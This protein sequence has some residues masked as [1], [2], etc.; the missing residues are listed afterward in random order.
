M[1]RD[2]ALLIGKES[3]APLANSRPVQLVYRKTVPLLGG[4]YTWVGTRELLSY[5]R[6]LLHNAA[7]IVKNVTL[8]ADIDEG[9]FTSSI[10]AIPE[11]MLYLEGTGISPEFRE[12]LLM[13]KYLDAYWYRLLIEPHQNPDRIY[14]SFQGVLNQTPNLVGK[15]SIT[16]TAMVML[17]EVID[18]HYLKA[19]KGGNL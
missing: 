15:A 17:Q 5:Q 2:R 16:L 8:S 19:L 6:P 10:T 4:A 14:A 3:N 9:D 1:I 18:D 7:Y 11:F 13:P 12:A